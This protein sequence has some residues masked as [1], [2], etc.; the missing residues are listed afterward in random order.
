VFIRNAVSGLLE[1]VMVR[2]MPGRRPPGII[3]QG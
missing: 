3:L 2:T 1:F